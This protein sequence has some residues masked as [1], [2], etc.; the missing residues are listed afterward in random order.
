MFGKTVLHFKN[1]SESVSHFPFN[2]IIFSRQFSAILSFHCILLFKLLCELLVGKWNIP[3]FSNILCRQNGTAKQNKRVFLNSCTS[4]LLLISFLKS[5]TSKS[6][7]FTYIPFLSDSCRVV[8]NLAARGLLKR[9]LD[10]SCLATGW[11]IMW[12]GANTLKIMAR[13]Q[14]IKGKDDEHTS[15][16]SWWFNAHHMFPASW[17]L[18]EHKCYRQVLSSSFATMFR[19]ASCRIAK[20]VLLSV[21]YRYCKLRAQS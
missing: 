12:V 21:V 16:Y 4:L 15:E 14:P 2:S 10:S 13:C 18:S 11:P 17:P 6:I 7:D 20:S 1:A 8:L 19:Y 3:I 9:I 5:D